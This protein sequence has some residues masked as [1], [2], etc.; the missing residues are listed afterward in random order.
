MMETE[1]RTRGEEA[2]KMEGAR[3]RIE[4]TRRAER[5]GKERYHAWIPV[6]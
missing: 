4:S 3:E 6:D 5:R 2:C 1:A